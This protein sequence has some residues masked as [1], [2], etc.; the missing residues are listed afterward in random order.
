MLTY[1]EWPLKKYHCINL[2]TC[3]VHCADMCVCVC[4]GGGGGGPVFAM[5]SFGGLWSIKQICG[6][7]CSCVVLWRSV[8]HQAGHVGVCILV[9]AIWYCGGLW[10][11]IHI[12][13]GVSVPVIAMWS[14]GGLWSIVHICGVCVPVFTMWYCEGLWSIM[15]ICEVCVPVF[16]MWS[17][18]GFW[19]IVHICWGVWSRQ[20]AT[21]A[22]TLNGSSVDNRKSATRRKS[23]QCSSSQASIKLQFASSGTESVLGCTSWK[24]P[25]SGWLSSCS[26]PCFVFCIFVY[27]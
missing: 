20:P 1:H 9:F 27:L 5:W 26:S 10:S 14:F 25:L 13:E 8:V 11:I 16:A 22:R 3:V 4:G 7:M 17:C 21:L 23:V 18:G 19:S 15:H 2:I 12:C 24:K 6:C